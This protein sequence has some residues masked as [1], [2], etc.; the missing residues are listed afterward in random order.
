MGMLVAGGRSCQTCHGQRVVR[1]IRSGMLTGVKMPCRDCRETGQQLTE[2]GREV[3]DL[4]AEN[5][6]LTRKEE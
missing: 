1:V 2:L 5:F 6:V 3:I 4:L